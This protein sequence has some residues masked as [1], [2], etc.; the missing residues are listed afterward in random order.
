ME[1]NEGDEVKSLGRL[2]SVPVGD[3][4]TGRVVD[5]LGN[6]LDGMGPVGIW[7]EGYALY[8]NGI[9]VATYPAA[10]HRVYLPGL[11]PATLHEFD[12]VACDQGGNCTQLDSSRTVR[13]RLRREPALH[14]AH[15]R[16]G[17]AAIPSATRLATLSLSRAA[18][19]SAAPLSR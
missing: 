1:I 2:L 9:H 15:A 8:R 7:N 12:L 16:R 14:A 17:V 19:A 6:P 11:T 18:S 5:P 13:T 3:A 4:I 10:T